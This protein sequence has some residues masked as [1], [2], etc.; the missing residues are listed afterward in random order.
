M[1]R[2][3]RRTQ[4]E[5]VPRTTQAPM[6]SDPTSDRMSHGRGPQG[7]ASRPGG[8]VIQA[9]CYAPNSAG[10]GCLY[11]LCDLLRA[12]GYPAFITGSRRTAPQFDAPL[13]TAEDAAELCSI[14]FTALYPETVPGN[15]LRASSVIRWVL[16]RPGLLGG[17]PVYAAGE[18]VYYYAE[19]FLPY[20]RN[21]VAGRLY[22]P[23][24][25]ERIFFA[26]GR[27]LAIRGVECFYVG[28]SAWR[29]GVC[30]R[31]VTYEI[32]RTSPAKA[33][34]GR[35]LRASRVLY[36]FDN[37]TILTYEALLCGCPVVI[38]PD[39]TQTRQDYE[40]QE[41]GMDGISWGIEEYRGDPVDVPGVR[42]RY[43]AL[44]QAF[45]RQLAVLIEGS[46]HRPVTDGERAI[47]MHADRILGRSHFTVG[48]ACRRAA[49]RAVAARKRATRRFHSWR[50]SLGQAAKRERWLVEQEA[51]YGRRPPA[52]A[53]D[54]RPRS[55][56]CF[57]LG[58]GRWRE[59]FCSRDSAF[60]IALEPDCDYENLL[61]LLRSTRL[62]VCFDARSPMTRI[63]L[64]QGCAV[65]VVS[66]DGSAR[67]LDGEKRR[68][69]AA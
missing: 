41:L 57:Y 29:E 20:I 68:D 6:A 16:N 65:I 17:D 43:E 3:D 24:I 2:G 46:G 63:A 62:L 47:W 44:K 69:R 58:K 51:M 1:S 13:I 45:A 34:L 66:A 18:T 21:D 59:G 27:D 38:V 60:H 31:R 36:C 25:D 61:I 37:S 35:L 48:D 32:T 40:R 8:F 54:E 55:L 67:R 49:A 7:A 33:E 56:V 4:T 28:K 19:A 11:R 53:G 39:G 26:D 15:P 10:V 22:M 52:D 14:G 42:S 5:A 23:T 50:R 64:E 30:D 12:R 9:P